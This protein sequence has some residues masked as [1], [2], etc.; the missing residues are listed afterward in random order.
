MACQAE[1][2]SGIIADHTVRIMA[3]G[4]L[5]TVGAADLVRS[6]DSLQI[7]HIAMTFVA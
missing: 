2:P 3:V 7:R 5:K 1:V 4:A 6:G